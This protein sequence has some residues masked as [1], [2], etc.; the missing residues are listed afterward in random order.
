[1]PFPPSPSRAVGDPNFT[2]WLLCK[3]YLAA[4][5]TAPL[6]S[7][8]PVPAPLA[9]SLSL[10]LSLS[11]HPVFPVNILSQAGYGNFKFMPKGK[12]ADRI[13]KDD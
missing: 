4:K 1:M 6:S 13:E 11:V 8:P 2:R 7:L 3:I 10:S 5:E 9:L 12:L